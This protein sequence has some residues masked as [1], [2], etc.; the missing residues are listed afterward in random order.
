LGVRRILLSPHLSISEVQELARV[1]NQYNVET[2]VM[3]QGVRCAPTILGMCRMSSYFDMNIENE[4]LRCL[5]W[6][7][8]SKRSGICYRPCAQEWNDQEGRGWDLTPH[9]FEE[10]HLLPLYLQAGVGAFKI[11]GR[12]LPAKRI[13]ELVERMTREMENIGSYV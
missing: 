11:G 6:S 10:I 3:I 7:G 9:S 5:I 2:E 13:A 4:G 8:S 1:L 12:G